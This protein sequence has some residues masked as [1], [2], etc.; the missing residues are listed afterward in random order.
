MK[1]GNGYSRL[2]ELVADLIIETQKT[3]DELSERLDATNNKLDTLNNKVDTMTNRVG[4]LE[5]Q[6]AKTNVELRDMR[7]SI[8]KVAD[9]LDS[10]N[11]LDNR[12]SRLEKKVFFKS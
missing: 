4:K 7:L 6:Q 12:V 10:L 5:E 9:K 1:N 2:E 8:M 3:R 11:K